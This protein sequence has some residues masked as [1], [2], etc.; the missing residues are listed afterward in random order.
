MVR[1]TSVDKIL[2]G[3]APVSYANR[4]SWR[5]LQMDCPDLRRVHAHLSQ[6]TRPNAKK[7]KQNVVKRYLRKVTIKRD[8]LLVVRSSEPFLPEKEL[9]VVPQHV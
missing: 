3:Q 9:T 7:S 6:G 2:A 4:A 5:N 8:G 1:G